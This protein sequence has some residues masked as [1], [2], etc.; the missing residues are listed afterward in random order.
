MYDIA[1]YTIALYDETSM[2]C[3]FPVQDLQILMQTMVQTMFKNGWNVC[4][5]G[6]N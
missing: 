4:K 5:H 2:E 1:L 3:K 6:E